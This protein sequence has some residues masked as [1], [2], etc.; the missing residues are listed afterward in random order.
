MYV[1]LADG[2]Q[3]TCLLVQRV[4][5]LEEPYLDLKGRAEQLLEILVFK[6]NAITGCNLGFSPLRSM[7]Y[8]R[9]DAGQRG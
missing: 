2:A 1:K 7:F 9:D 4:L 5:D 8:V 6:I 3:G